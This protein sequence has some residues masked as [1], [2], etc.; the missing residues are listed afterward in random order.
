MHKNQKE[1]YKICLEN[2]VQED[3]E[4]QEIG[5]FHHKKTRPMKDEESGFKAFLILTAL[6]IGII[7]FLIHLSFNLSRKS[8]YP[9]RKAITETIGDYED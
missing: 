4:F 7:I 6:A 5:V 8:D 1:Y 9:V 3:E 2:L